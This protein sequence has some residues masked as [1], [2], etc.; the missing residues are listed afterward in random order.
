MFGRVPLGRRNLFAD[1]RRL[2]ASVTAVGL[3]VMLMLLLAGFDTGVRARS[4]LLESRLGADL[5]IAQPGTNSLQGDVSIIPASD[6]NVARA[7]PGVAW[8]GPLR[9]LFVIV[10]LRGYKQPVYL[11]GSVQ[12]ERGGPWRISRGRR[13][14]ADDEIVISPVLAHRYGLHLGGTLPL[15]GRS[16]RIVGFASDAAGFMVTFA[17]VTHSATDSL[18]SA[19]GTT[20]VVLIAARPGQAA[21]VQ[22]RLQAKG[23]NVVPKAEMAA[24]DRRLL[25]GI[26]GAF[27]A[28]TVLI[29]FLAGVAVISLTAY[30]SVVE[31]RREYGVVKAIGATGRHLSAVVVGQSLVLAAFGLA[32]GW[33]LYLLGRAL[34][35]W[36]RPQFAVVITRGTIEL[37]ASAALLMAVL[38]ALL[39]ARRLEALDPA[40]AYRGA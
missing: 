31:R 15:M 10:D 22:A 27:L 23:F 6:V 26:F 20:S 14:V 3:A 40:T 17:Y 34:I 38:G 37:A 35:L 8:A 2:A 1:R 36:Y 19:P 29:A 16:F 24:A 18:L 7:D 5:Y 32:A 13:A 25:T 11:L 33:L 39:P 28:L 12:G 21:A 30:T 4:T 9:A